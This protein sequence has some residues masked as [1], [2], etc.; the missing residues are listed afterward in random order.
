M[1]MLHRVDDYLKDKDNMLTV[2]NELKASGDIGFSGISVYANTDY[3]EIAESGIDAV[4][5]PLN[6]FDCGQV[7]GGGIDK[8]RKAGMMIF[9][10]SV[11]LQG[12]IFR[13]PDKLE[14]GMEFA[15]ETLVKFRMLCDKYNL[16]PA[17]L[18]I[19]YVSSLKGFTSLVLGCDNPDQVN[20]N[21]ELI[22]ETVQLSDEQINEIHEAFKDTPR[23]LLDPSQWGTT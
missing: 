19:S 3:G 12:L 1:L 23:K 11:Y 21:A 5:L 14:E 9:I 6:L 16:S 8:L 15:R 2:L 13:D 20:S 4:Q 10:R 17:T 22:G 7:I 18:A